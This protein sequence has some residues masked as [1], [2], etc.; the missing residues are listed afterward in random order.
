MDDIFKDLSS[1]CDPHPIVSIR[2]SQPGKKEGQTKKEALSVVS[3][4]RPLSAEPAA[5]SP[6]ALI[7]RSLQ[8]MGR[9][10]ALSWHRIKAATA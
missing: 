6:R 1:L 9:A 7:D 3:K 4:A 5:W 10:A 8:G 2:G